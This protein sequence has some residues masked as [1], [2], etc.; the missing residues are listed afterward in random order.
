MSL[1]HLSRWGPV[2][3]RLHSKR[4]FTISR[5]Y[6]A[7][8]SSR[9][10][11]R[12]VPAL[13]KSGNQI[14]FNSRHEEDVHQWVCRATHVEKRDSQDLGHFVIHRDGKDGRDDGREPADDP[15]DNNDSGNCQQTSCLRSG[16]YHPENRLNY[17]IIMLMVYLKIR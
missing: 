8:L 17:V 9:I 7:D 2:T 6:G 14:R 16:S 3:P 15:R 4:C 10:R 11:G 5:T 1:T 12:G 13:E